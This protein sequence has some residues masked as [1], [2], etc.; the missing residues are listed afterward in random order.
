V[1][2]VAEEAAA[3]PP[4]EQTADRAVATPPEIADRK[5][6][7]PLP[8]ALRTVHGTI[9]VDVGV[10]VAADG[11]VQSAELLAP[12][13]SPYFNRL[14]LAAAQESRFQPSTGGGSLV[15]RYEY[16]RAGVEVSQPAP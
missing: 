1:V 8:Q 13:Q 7:A 14:S 15:L 6:P 12:A 5:A 3:P 11:T 4:D 9:R 10:A 2:E 16:T